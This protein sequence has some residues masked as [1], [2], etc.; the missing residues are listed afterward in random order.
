MRVNNEW[1][2]A[3]GDEVAW[4]VLRLMR[5]VRDEVKRDNVAP[6]DWLIP[7]ASSATI[8]AGQGVA[9][10]TRLTLTTTDLARGRHGS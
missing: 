5:A 9:Q 7:Y 6:V 10:T 1:T 8:S 2:D 3:D 4:M